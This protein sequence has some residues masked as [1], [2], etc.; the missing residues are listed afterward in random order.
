M[1]NEIEKLDRARK[2]ILK[3]KEYTKPIQHTPIL[4]K[5]YEGELRENSEMW[6]NSLV[7]KSQYE[8]TSMLCSNW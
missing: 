7:G 3:R 8:I 5:R 1:T 4:D 6:L 2:V